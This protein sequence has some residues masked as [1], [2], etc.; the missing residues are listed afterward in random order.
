MF[1]RGIQPLLLASSSSGSACHSAGQPV[2]QSIR[3]ATSGTPG[4]C[5]A[6]ILG[7]GHPI[8]I[9]PGCQSWVRSSAVSLASLYSCWVSRPQAQDGKMTWEFGQRQ[10]WRQRLR[11]PC[12]SSLVGNRFP[13]TSDWVAV[14]TRRV[15]VG[16]RLA[17][18]SGARAP[19]PHHFLQFHEFRCS[20]GR[21]RLAG[22]LTL[23]RPLVGTT[24]TVSRD[25]PCR[26]QP[27]SPRPHRLR[28]GADHRRADRRLLRW[29]CRDSITA[30]TSINRC[31]I[32]M[33]GIDAGAR[34]KG[35][36]PP[37][38]S[39]RRA[40]APGRH[41]RSSWLTIRTGANSQGSGVVGIQC[42]GKSRPQMRRGAIHGERP[43]S[44]NQ[45]VG[46]HL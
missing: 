31:G 16:I 14:R 32:S 29:F 38:R 37:L 25:A 22:L 11:L 36:P 10:S 39:R 3:P 42:D 12:D 46:Q 7:R 24:G 35:E 45:S 26:P 9:T 27:Y 4:A 13:P 8:G 15:A 44:G 40:N 2:M 1:S 6:E 18:C 43:A 17:A 19:A 30:P 33:Q 21:E 5:P 34:R 23:S 20:G 28:G 41:Q